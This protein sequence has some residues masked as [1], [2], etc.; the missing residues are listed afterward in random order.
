MKFPYGSVTFI[1]YSF[2]IFLSLCAVYVVAVDMTYKIFSP[3]ELIVASGLVLL[4]AYLLLIY[5]DMVRD[6]S[7]GEYDWN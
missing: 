3:F 7:V 6:I 2:G 4:T 1:L 5:S